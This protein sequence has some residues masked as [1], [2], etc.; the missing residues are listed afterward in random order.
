MK[1]A[2]F[3]ICC[4]MS[5][6]VTAGIAVVVHPTNGAEL[7]KDDL[8]RLY[9]GRTSNF[10]DGSSAVPINLGDASSLRAMF[11]EKALGRSSSQIKAYWS[12]L[13]FTGKGTPP[14][15]VAT[16]AEVLQLVANNPNIV[17]Y[18]DS[19]E[20]TPAVKVVLTID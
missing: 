6:T 14:K 15:E 11:D 1:T 19:A 20:V 13:V 10:P 18:I 16:P 4:L 17:G 9:T 8:S 5:A 3:A 2:I 12:K 7:S